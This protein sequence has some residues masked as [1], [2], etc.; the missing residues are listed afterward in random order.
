MIRNLKIGP[1]LLVFIGVQLLILVAVGVG[2]LIALDNATQTQTKLSELVE[3]AAS[4]NKLS[5]AVQVD[6]RGVVVDP[7]LG[8]ITWE[9]ASE[10]LSAAKTRLEMIWDEYLAGFSPEKIN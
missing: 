8:N 9:S 2:A 10:R 4:I 1:R 5:E 7:Y 3:D 6:L